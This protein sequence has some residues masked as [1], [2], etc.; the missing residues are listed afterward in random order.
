M[1]LSIT[2]RSTTTTTI[3][4]GITGATPNGSGDAF[5]GEQYRSWSNAPGSGIIPSLTF[6]GL[7]PG[8]TY[9]I[10]AI[11]FGTNNEY[12]DSDTTTATTD[13]ESSSDPSLS[14]TFGTITANSITIS[15]ITAT[16]FT[17]VSYEIYWRKTSEEKSSTSGTIT[18]S[19]IPY[20]ITGLTAGT[21]YA[22][23]VKG[24]NSSGTIVW[25]PPASSSPFEKS[26]LAVSSGTIIY[27]GGGWHHVQ[28]FV[29]SGRWH[30][31]QSFVYSSGWHHA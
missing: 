4:I 8:T 14:V 6:T 21:T 24:T 12:V 31:A 27:V 11:D 20:P 19:S 25:E 18:S 26:T 23:R 29:Y 15:S 28:P 1:G 5:I 3:T 17:P 16:D 13:S 30:T 22:I 7:S 2:V 9:S 10:G